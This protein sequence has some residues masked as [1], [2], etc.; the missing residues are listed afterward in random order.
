MCSGHHLIQIGSDIQQ[1]R[2][3]IV[4]RQ[5]TWRQYLYTTVTGPTTATA[6]KVIIVTFAATPSAIAGATRTTLVALLHSLTPQQ[7]GHFLRATVR[8]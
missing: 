4:F 8:L 7:L 6:I 1:V 5:Q 2:D 3:L